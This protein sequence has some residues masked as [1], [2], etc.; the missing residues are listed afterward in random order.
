MV[1]FAPDVEEIG[2]SRPRGHMQ[3][4][5]HADEIARLRGLVRA[6]AVEI[7]E[8][9]E[10]DV[11][12]NQR[13]I[14]MLAAAAFQREVDMIHTQPTCTQRP[15]I[16]LLQLRLEL[17]DVRR[18][19]AA[20]EKTT[21]SNKNVIA[22]RDCQIE[23]L[24]MDKDRLLKEALDAQRS[25]SSGSSSA[26]VED[27]RS[28]LHEVADLQNAL[29]DVA[30]ERAHLQQAL[31]AAEQRDS[32]QSNGQHKADS[33]GS[34]DSSDSSDSSDE[35]EEERGGRRCDRTSIDEWI[36]AQYPSLPAHRR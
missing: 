2:R 34:K 17:A 24:R 21:A 31:A 29:A 36:K 22:A 18:V 7:E 9:R 4:E 27:E 13:K 14:G 35:E 10:L 12:A 32:G 15:D 5:K 20:A 8:L 25:S 28:S 16:E 23:E 11:A 30:V 3:R 19:L 33:K 1:Q 26:S 6:Q